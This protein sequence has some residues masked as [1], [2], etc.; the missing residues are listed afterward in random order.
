[1][2]LT[3]AELAMNREDTE[4]TLPSVCNLVITARSRSPRG[5]SIEVYITGEDFPCAVDPFELAPE[6]EQ[7]QRIGVN[8]GWYITVPLTI[9]VA[10]ND[11]IGFDVEG[12]S[13]L[14]EIVGSTAPE[15]D[16]SLRTLIVTDTR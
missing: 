11:R 6:S 4:K 8:R 7:A 3:A 16:A 15:S 5:E 1:M 14:T 9:V 10:E 12:E 13:R 2:T